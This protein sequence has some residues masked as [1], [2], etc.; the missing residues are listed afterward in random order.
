MKNLPK[1][2]DEKENSRFFDNLED[3]IY[4]QEKNLDEIREK[5]IGLITN[6]FDELKK[7]FRKDI[8]SVAA[9]RANE[10]KEFNSINENLRDSCFQ[11][12]TSANLS[13]VDS[14]RDACSKILNVFNQDANLVNKN[15]SASL[16][17]FPHLTKELELI[18]S[19]NN[20]K[21]QDLDWSFF[22]SN[23]TKEFGKF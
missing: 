17:Q 11:I 13:E 21:L 9:Q 12:F 19:I 22:A 18:I 23:D 7:K 15:P 14:I 10:I 2:F 3:K 5:V 16:N 4:E 6:R 8:E 20:N 1:I